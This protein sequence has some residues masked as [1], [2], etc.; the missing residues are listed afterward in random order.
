MPELPNLF[1]SRPPVTIPHARKKELRDCAPGADKGAAAAA[2]LRTQKPKERKTKMT[3][4]ATK[5]SNA[6]THHAYVVDEYAKDQKFWT[7]IGSVLSAEWPFSL[8]GL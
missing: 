1:K 7:R 4:K 8:K 3:K 2:V 5:I 6:P